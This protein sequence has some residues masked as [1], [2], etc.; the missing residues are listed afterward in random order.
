ML[1]LSWKQKMCKYFLIS[2][3][4]PSHA[5]GCSIS[6][7]KFWQQ[8][9]LFAPCFSFSHCQSTA[10]QVHS[11]PMKNRTRKAQDIMYT[12]ATHARCV[13]K[14]IL[15]HHWLG[16]EKGCFPI[17]TLVLIFKHPKLKTSCSVTSIFYIYLYY[18]FYFLTHLESCKFIL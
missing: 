16:G 6:I 15:Y 14:I 8:K 5:H 11:L 17:I 9:I 12:V 3:L 7:F 2:H 18:T 10:M 4:Q 1:L 13:C